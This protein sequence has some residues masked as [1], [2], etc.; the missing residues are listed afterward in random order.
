MG[1]M[2]ENIDEWESIY[3]AI[4]PAKSASLATKVIMSVAKVSLA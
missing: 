4:R 1:S 3:L 2:H